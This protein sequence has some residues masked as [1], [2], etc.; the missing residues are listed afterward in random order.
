MENVNISSVSAQ[1]EPIVA[2][3]KQNSNALSTQ[4]KSIPKS[5]LSFYLFGVVVLLVTG[6]A[7][8]L[9]SRPTTPEKIT[10][11]VDNQTT[12]QNAD[13]NTDQN[14]DTDTNSNT[15]SDTNTSTTTET[16]SKPNISPETITTSGSFKIAF[17]GK[18]VKKTGMNIFA[19]MKAPLPA[20]DP[21]YSQYAEDGY[22]YAIDLDTDSAYYTVGR[23]TEGTYK[24][25]EVIFG[26]NNIYSPMLDG[27]THKMMQYIILQKGVKYVVFNHT[28]NT[29]NSDVLIVLPARLVKSTDIKVDTNNSIYSNIT[30]N[31]DFSSPESRVESYGLLGF[32][33]NDDVTLGSKIGSQQLYKLKVES[34]LM[35][36]NYLTK[37][38]S[39][40]FKGH[41]VSPMSKSLPQN[42]DV[43]TIN[44][45][46]PTAH[47]NTEP[48][49]ASMPYE[50]GGGTNI[51]N[52]NSADLE[53]I[54]TNAV[55][56]K[57]Y[58]YKDDT[59][60]SM[61][62]KVYDEDYLNEDAQLPK[63]NQLTEDDS[64][65]LSYAEYLKHIPV[66]YWKNEFGEY[67]QFLNEN[68]IMV[69]GCAKPAVYI[70][71][72]KQMNVTV[73]VIPNGNLTLIY[74]R[75][76]S[77]NSWSVVANPDGILAVSGQ[78]YDYLWWESQKTGALQY[79][80]HTGFLLSKSN[81]DSE[82]TT[83]LKQ[84]N[85]NQKEISQFKE[86]WLPIMNKENSDNLYVTFL[87]N[88]EIDQI[89]KL[90]ITPKPTS[91][92]RVFMVYKAVASNYKVTPQKLQKA[93]RVGYTVVEWGGAREK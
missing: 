78:K 79:R 43:F 89:A 12:D 38:A 80:Q 59:K 4:F 16:D 61:L 85:L 49:T 63:Y 23:I 46:Y 60:D 67:V 18:P 7:I 55:G 33:S 53:V 90:E 37:T 9:A 2:P 51:V 88:S 73:S 17:T 31:A 58:K 84:M 87:F 19:P 11:N 54:G 24:D 77:E 44:W 47:S 65:A 22:E 8:V 91:E 35:D 34:Q 5:R 50:C 68:F 21:E 66:F 72:T 41:Y 40:F 62:R 52:I 27:T 28:K 83:L 86:F 30:L 26:F 20:S 6:I 69:G 76:N 70:Y 32:Y 25:Y 13:Q 82:L 45:T 36:T 75:F 10:Q 14:T 3:S 81:L 39:G 56:S 1:V 71:P 48:Y 42:S 64:A 29:N 15:T 57:L 74:P 92:F 93:N